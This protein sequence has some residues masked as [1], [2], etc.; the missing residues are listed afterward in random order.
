MALLAALL[1]PVPKVDVNGQFLRSILLEESVSCCSA[2][3]HSFI[4]DDSVFVARLGSSMSRYP[5]LLTRESQDI[6]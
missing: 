5:S 1:L 6:E 3:S 2:G 4:F